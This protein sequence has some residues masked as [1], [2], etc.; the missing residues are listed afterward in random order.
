MVLRNPD[1][2]YSLS[3]LPEAVS[4]L[5]W[6][7]AFCRRS[8]LWFSA[9]HLPGHLPG[10]ARLLCDQ[11]SSGCIN[12]LFIAGFHFLDGDASTAGFEKHNWKT[13]W[14]PHLQG[15]G[16]ETVMTVFATVKS[17]FSSDFHI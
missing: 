8:R 6:G 7:Q 12:D 13:W 17:P 14:Y 16:A 11:E 9:C 3:L 4:V 1:N 10:S 15:D 5:A 2:I